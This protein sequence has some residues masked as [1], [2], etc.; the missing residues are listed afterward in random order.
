MA[1]LRVVTVYICVPIGAHFA[2]WTHQVWNVAVVIG[3]NSTPPANWTI[4]RL[5]T[6]GRRAGMARVP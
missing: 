1:P 4:K 3:A 6:V 2:A 5:S